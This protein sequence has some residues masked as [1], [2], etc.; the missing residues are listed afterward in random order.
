MSDRSGI[1]KQ[2]DELIDKLHNQIIDNLKKD[3]VDKSYI[4][5]CR[6]EHILSEDQEEIYNIGFKDALK[7]A[8]YTIEM[9]RDGEL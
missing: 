2:A 1:F 5:E 3:I 8:I 9:F 4:F 6:C 7:S